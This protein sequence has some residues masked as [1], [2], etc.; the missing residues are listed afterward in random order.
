MPPTFIQMIKIEVGKIMS[1]FMGWAPYIAAVDELLSHCRINLE[2]QSI[3]KNQLSCLQCPCERRDNDVFNIKL[4]DFPANLLS[5]SF[6]QFCN[7]CVE[8]HGVWL[9]WT[10]NGIEG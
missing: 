8:Y 6:S 9:I 7:W 10:V 5:L 1:K 4:F 2:G 3:F